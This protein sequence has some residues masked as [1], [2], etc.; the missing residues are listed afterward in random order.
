MKKLSDP[1]FLKKKQMTFE[2][3]KKSIDEELEF[4]KKKVAKIL[5]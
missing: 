3:K 5:E 2:K 1:K 4:Y